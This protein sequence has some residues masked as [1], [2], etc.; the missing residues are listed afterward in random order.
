MNLQKAKKVIEKYVGYD[1]YKFLE[2]G[3]AQI[4]FYCGLSFDD[5]L[6]NKETDFWDTTSY[7]PSAQPYFDFEKEK[8]KEVKIILF[9]QDRMCGGI[10][11]HELLHGA[12]L[13]EHYSAWM[14]QETE[15]CDTNTLVIGRESIDKIKE[16]YGLE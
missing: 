4:N 11:V 3:D 16:L 15:M 9:A 10:E 2:N 7:F 6:L 14:E 13:R 5:V 12:G 8:I 1:I